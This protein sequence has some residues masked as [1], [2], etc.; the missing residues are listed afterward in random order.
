M[1]SVL[2]V[3]EPR[4]GICSQTLP[5]ASHTQIEMFGFYFRFMVMDPETLAK[6]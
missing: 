2:C 5:F 6:V 4:F 1:K 3:D